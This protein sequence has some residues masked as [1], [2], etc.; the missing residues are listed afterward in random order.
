[1]SSFTPPTRPPVEQRAGGAV[2]IERPAEL[3]PMAEPQPRLRISDFPDDDVEAFPIEQPRSFV[4]E[5]ASTAFD[6][7][8]RGEVRVAQGGG[9]ARYEHR[10]SGHRDTHREAGESKGFFQRMADVGR[11]LSTR[12]DDGGS[13]RP[14]ASERVQVVQKSSQVEEKQHKQHAEDDQYLDIP[15]FLRRQAN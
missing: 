15:A 3:P 4:R 7:M 14:Q 9:S 5:P 12:G 13:A 6:A 11:A 2:R 10:D 8:E 1:V